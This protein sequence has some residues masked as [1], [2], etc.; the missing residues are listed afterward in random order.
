MSRM[1]RIG[2]VS[3]VALLACLLSSTA[4]AA[5]YAGHDWLSVGGDDGNTRYSVLSQINV[6]NIQRLGG[7]WFKE[8]R[9]TTRATPVTSGGLSF[10]PQTGRLYVVGMV[11]SWLYR[12]FETPNALLVYHPPGTLEYGIYAAID[13]N[14]NKISW[15]QRSQWGLAGGSGAL[16]TAGGLLLHT[17]GDGNLQAQE[18]RTGKLLWQFQTGFLGDP[19]PNSNAGGVPLATYEIGHQQYIAAPMGKGLWALA[20]DGRLPPRPA[21]TAPGSSFGFTGI[22]QPLPADGTGEITLAVARTG[23]QGEGVVG[24]AVGQD[25]F[26]DEYAIAPG[27]ARVG[28]GVTFKWT[29][30]GVAAHS[31][32]AQDGSWS[33]G[34]IQPAQSVSMSIAKPGTYIYYCK[35][36]PWSQGELLVTAVGLGSA[37][38]NTTGAYTTEQAARGRSS[39]HAN[40]TNGCHMPDLSA[41]A[42][43]PALA[44]EVFLQHWRGQSANDLLERVRDTMPQQRPHSLAGQ[45]YF[46]IV[47]FLL[48]AN[49]LPAGHSELNG[50]PR[51]LGAI[52]LNPA[53]EAVP[54]HPG[55]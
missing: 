25:H 1:S 13:T 7:A 21:P 19:G 52:A 29:N 27:R 6:D 47:A 20:L 35:E 36:H 9:H 14:T 54:A 30:M 43:A 17:E 2:Q 22:V 37:N 24:G 33:T 32:V 23:Q 8:L 46:D 40:C 55:Q 45:V 11:T 28:A 10:D 26:V 39:Y 34:E 4:A 15:Q 49:G 31:I 5:S 41:A 48:Q 50:D 18:A 3:V 38:S 51:A 42:R 53:G 44:G 12:R 16:T